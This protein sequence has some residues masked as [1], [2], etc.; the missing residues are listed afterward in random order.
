M[1]I[2]LS[3]QYHRFK[4]LSD[5]LYDNDGDDKKCD[6][7]NIDIKIIKWLMYVLLLFVA[8]VNKKIKLKSF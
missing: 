8:A 1:I 2:Y 6:V 7:I 5:T 3:V 4:W